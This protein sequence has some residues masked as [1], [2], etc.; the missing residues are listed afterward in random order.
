MD[1]CLG[2]FAPCLH[3]HCA[4]RAREGGGA[5]LRLIHTEACRVC[6]VVCWICFY[7]IYLELY[8]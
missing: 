8:L 3:K 2:V 6:E 5:R 7:C 4:C 1:C